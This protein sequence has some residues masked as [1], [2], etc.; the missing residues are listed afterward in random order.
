[1]VEL[2]LFGSTLRV[3]NP[4]MRRRHFKSYASSDVSPRF[5]IAMY[6]ASL[7]LL[8]DLGIELHRDD[9][10]DVKRRRQLPNCPK[11]SI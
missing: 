2:N 4:P 3:S 8:V 10:H 11:K 1:M 5:L 6:A 7:L 9:G